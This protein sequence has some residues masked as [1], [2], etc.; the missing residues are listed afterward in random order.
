MLL[1]SFSIQM[2]RLPLYCANERCRAWEPGRSKCLHDRRAVFFKIA[3]ATCTGKGIVPLCWL[4]KAPVQVSRAFYLHQF[5]TPEM[6]QINELVNTL[7]ILANTGP[8]PNVAE[9]PHQKMAK[10]CLKLLEDVNNRIAEL[11][12]NISK[13]HHYLMQM[14]SMDEIGCVFTALGYQENGLTV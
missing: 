3:L 2:N 13:A 9:L 6:K 11:E 4:P 7:Q 10:D 14:E 1:A 5:K 12:F 8:S